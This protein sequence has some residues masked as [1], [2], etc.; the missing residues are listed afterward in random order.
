MQSGPFSLHHRAN[1]SPPLL[2]FVSKTCPSKKEAEHLAASMALQ[3]LEGMARQRQLGPVAV[4]SPA[5]DSSL[6][7]LPD[8]LP[9]EPHNTL[10]HNPHSLQ[11]HAQQFTSVVQNQGPH[12]PTPAPLV[13]QSLLT[14]RSFGRQT[15]VALPHH[16]SQMGS[17][18]LR[19]AGTATHQPT[20]H[21]HSLAPTP[22]VHGPQHFTSPPRQFNLP[23]SRDHTAAMPPSPAAHVYNTQLQQT[24]NSPALQLPT[25]QQ[26][27]APPTSQQFVAPPTSQQFV[28]PPSS[29]QFV[30]PPSS[31][32][33]VAP[34]ISQ[35]FVAPPSSQHFV[36]PPI[37]QQ[38]FASVAHP[39]LLPTV[40]HASASGPTPSA[41]QGLLPDPVT[42][43][44]QLCTVRGWPAPQ[45][46]FW[47]KRRT[48]HQVSVACGPHEPFC[49]SNGQFG[50]VDI[51]RRMVAQQALQN[52]SAPAH[53]PFSS[54]GGSGEPTGVFQLCACA[55]PMLLC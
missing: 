39:S 29:Q 24:T 53:S 30:A 20:A 23:S 34:P 28:A 31:Q 9:V 7:H 16:P 43:L 50:S 35:Q 54:R 15:T 19:S 8:L 14:E 33:F 42:E 3:K 21:Q 38:Q 47:E 52:L 37:S 51:A 44:E 48:F 49:I 10:Q 27:V 11:S 17:P 45:Y 41:S 1:Y 55:C 40:S 18:E 13:G 6:P 5:A 46:Q 4:P 12:T 2:R 22:H 25:S 32:Q 36:A 26:F